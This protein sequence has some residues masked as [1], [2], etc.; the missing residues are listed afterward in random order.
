MAERPG[1]LD[2]DSYLALPRD[3]ENWLVKPLIPSGGAALLY[4]DP[5]VGKALA[6]DTPIKTTYGWKTM[7]TIEVGDEVYGSDDKP[8][9][10][11]ATTGFQ[12]MRPCFKF[13]FSD[14]TSIIADENHEWIVNIECNLKTSLEL[15]TE[16]SCP[17]VI[18]PNTLEYWEITSIKPVP[19]TAVRC[20]MVDSPNHLFKAGLNG[21]PTHNSY[22]GIQLALALSGQS[23]D[24]LSFPILRTG[25]VLYLQ[26][27]TPRGTW[28]LRF[29]EMLK[30]GKLKYDSSKL[31]L[32]DRDSVEMY[33]FD[34]LQPQHAQYLQS[35]VQVHQPVA[36]IIDTLRE[37]HSGDEDS[38][39]ISR[40]VI[41]NLTG[42]CEPAALILISHGRKPHPE[43]DRDLL[44]D[45]R[46]SSYI[47]GRMDA[48]MRLTKNKLYYTGRSI[49]AGDIKV[50][51]TDTG[52]WAPVVE[53]SE[54]LAMF[55]VT[56]D[57]SLISLRSKAKCL[58]TMIGI[59]EEAA[60][61]RLR[62]LDKVAPPPPTP[63]IVLD[64]QPN[65]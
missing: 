12:Y 58:A 38:S 4:G 10:V 27:D 21:V 19:M 47:T 54:K 65:L 51:R 22:L 18:S 5:K 37:V 49:E 17:I 15:Y 45:H 2:V 40:N 3:K 31:L 13:T 25:A 57:T 1:F 6:L 7:Q 42:A 39:T 9:M 56:T 41:A 44:A 64:N 32:A 60:L 59:T 34:I 33:P 46:G 16:F 8:Y 30:K 63:P 36:V 62:R 28:A 61:S 52:L 55:K 24:F 11:L 26:L 29:E 53:E 48:I 14:G 35:I 43:V 23:P 20:I 50:A